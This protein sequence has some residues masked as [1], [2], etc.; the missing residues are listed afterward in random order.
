MNR[1]LLVLLTL[2][3]ALF[4]AACGAARPSKYYSLDVP[5]AGPEQS[6]DAAPAT[7]G[8]RSFTLLVGR[9]AAPHLYRDDRIVYRTGAT[10]LGAYEYHRWAE[11]PS[12]MLEALL[13]RL[14]RASGKFASVQALASNAQGDF[15][16]RGRLHNFEEVADAALVA[17]V[18]F[19]LELLDRATGTVVW[20]HFYSH[21]EPVA[22]SSKDIQVAAVV[23]ALNRNVRRGLDQALASLD[24]WFAKNP[25]K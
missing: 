13:L 9:I 21:D 10:Q 11:P 3:S 14:L 19:E 12:D 1:R 7:A 16:L 15:I 25:K 8:A 5:A 6:R 2:T 23:E 24:S 22:A 18:A 4:L 20:T 17:R